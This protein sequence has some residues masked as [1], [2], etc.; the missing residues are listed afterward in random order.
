[1]KSLNKPIQ[2]LFDK[3][4]K[5]LEGQGWKKSATSEGG[6]TYDNGAGLRCAVGH[7]IPQKRTRNRLDNF[8]TSS[9]KGLAS[10]G[11][12]VIESPKVL[13][14]LTDAQSA[15]DDVYNCKRRKERFTWLAEEYNLTIPNS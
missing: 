13:Q 14:F 3:M 6:C 8:S 2:E 15:H 11:K 5:G 9:I 12:V 1:M 7:C 10:S 4:W